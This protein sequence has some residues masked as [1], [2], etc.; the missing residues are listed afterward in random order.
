MPSKFKPYFYGLVVVLVAMLVGLVIYLYA[1]PRQLKS[2]KSVP[3]SSVKTP[4]QAREYYTN[5]QG[6][7]WTIDPVADFTVSSA[8][9]AKISFLE[10]KIEP[11]KVSPGDTQRMRIVIQGVNGISSVIAE[12]E[13][14]HGTTTVEL[15]KTVLTNWTTIKNGALQVLSRQQALVYHNQAIKTD[16]S[17]SLIS[18]ALAASGDKEIWEGS[19]VVKDTSIRT[20]HTIFIAK[21]SENNERN[22]V[23]AWSDPAGWAAGGNVTATTSVSVSS[24]YGVDGGNLTIP[25]GTTITMLSGGNLIFNQTQY[26]TLQPA[27]GAFAA[28]NIVINAGGYIRSANVYYYD[29]DGD[30]WPAGTGGLATTTYS[31][32]ASSST[33]TINSVVYS[34]GTRVQSIDPSLTLDCNDSNSSLYQNLTGYQDSDLDGYTTGSGQSICSGAAL[35]SGWRSAATATDCNDSNANINPGDTAWWNSA[36]DFNCNSSI[37]KEWAPSGTNYPYSSTG[38][39]GSTADAVGICPG[40]SGTSI[41]PATC[42]SIPA[43]SGS[44]YHASA[45][46]ASCSGIASPANYIWSGSSITVCK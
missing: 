9:G 38:Y 13:T 16:A 26:I 14:D 23:L 25:A 8:P 3:L 34:R 17:S 11:L 33:T 10:G 40:S 45:I 19:W 6:K 18:P 42:G 28:G 4:A 44:V 35:P 27:V 12:V 37:E 1:A 32:S 2:P 46:G 21:D 29:N 7:R 22:L 31:T 20:Y 43:Y 41:A 30:G 36:T 24:V 5:A 15:H 39:T